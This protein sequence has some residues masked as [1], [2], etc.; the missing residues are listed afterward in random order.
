VSITSVV[1]G[2]VSIQMFDPIKQAMKKVLGVDIPAERPLVSKN[3]LQENW[4]KP[5]VLA[6]K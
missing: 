2:G 3:V 1:T 6:C 5:N 4:V